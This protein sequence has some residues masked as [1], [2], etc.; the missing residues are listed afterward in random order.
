MARP[1]IPG[2]SPC[3]IVRNVTAAT[4]FYR[5]MLGFDVTYQQPPIATHFLRLCSAMER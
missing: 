3:F 2:I 1:A 4:S 5:D